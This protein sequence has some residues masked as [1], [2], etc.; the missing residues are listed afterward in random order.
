MAERDDFG[1]F[2]MGFIVGGLTGAIV[3]LLFAPQSGEQTRT[4]IKEKAIELSDKAADTVEDALKQ[5]EAAADEGIKRA[6]SLLKTAQ[7]KAEDL[8]H[9]GQVI[10]EEQKAKFAEPRTKKVAGKP[11]GET[12]A[13]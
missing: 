10:L 11:S 9:Q 3:S 8:K 2:L 6:E 5:A 4:L 1:A 12:P 7:E 13:A